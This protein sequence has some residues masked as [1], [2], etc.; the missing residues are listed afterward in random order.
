MVGTPAPTPQVFAAL[1]ET[2]VITLHGVLHIG[3]ERTEITT[4]IGCAT[5]PKNDIIAAITLAKEVVLL[6]EP[7]G[8][9]IECAR[10]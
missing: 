5:S 1:G 7:D 9:W 4:V 10:Q 3:T 6:H 2:P 8:K